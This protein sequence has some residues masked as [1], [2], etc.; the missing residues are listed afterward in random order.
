MAT[1]MHASLLVL[2]LSVSTTSSA[3]TN[4]Y[5]HPQKDM[6]KEKLV[7]ALQWLKYYQYYDGKVSISSIYI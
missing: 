3:P 6:V 4:N 7:F 2:V 1:V 5:A